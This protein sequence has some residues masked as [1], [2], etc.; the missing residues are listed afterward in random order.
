LEKQHPLPLARRLAALYEATGKPDEAA[1]W[2]A[3]SEKN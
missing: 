2:K 1:K 3:L